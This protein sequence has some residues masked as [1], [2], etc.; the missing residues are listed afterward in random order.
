MMKLGTNYGG[1]WVPKELQLDSNSI[2]YLVGAGEDISFDLILSDNFDSYIYIIDPTN[3]A[4][5][6]FQQVKDFYADKNNKITGNIQSDYYTK[7]NN[8]NPNFNKI[9][10]LE[11]G[12]WNCKQTCKFYRQSN[13]AYVSQSL[14]D[15]MF[16]NIFDIVEVDTIKNIMDTFHHKNIDLL[17]LDIEGAELA[18]IENMFYEN[19]FPKYLLIE[20]DLK[21]K[22]KDSQN[23][24]N[25]IMKEINKYYTLLKNDNLNCTYVIKNL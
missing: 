23:K 5:K 19:I 15:G 2:I 17:K 8:L 25:E 7:I 21:L 12:L 11:V 20:F 22:N 4:I 16:S 1:W 13:E 3:K 18:V 9:C 6:H 24:T 14:V 10:F